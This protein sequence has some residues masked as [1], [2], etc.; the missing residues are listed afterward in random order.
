MKKF[1]N[2]IIIGIDHGYGNMKTASCCFST[3]LI[4]YDSEPLFTKELLVY[5]GKYYLI[6]EEHKEYI[7]TAHLC[8]CAT[9]RISRTVLRISLA[10]DIFALPTNAWNGSKIIRRMFFRTIACSICSR[11]AKVRYVSV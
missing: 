3:G 1:N 8:F 9:S 5:N 4:A 7:I 11:L 6:G 2:T 10:L